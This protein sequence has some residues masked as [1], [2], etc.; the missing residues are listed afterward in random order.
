MTSTVQKLEDITN[1]VLE[2]LTGSCAE[3]GITSDIIGRPSFACYPESPTHV[4]YRA[5]LEGSS[6]TDSGSLISLIDDWVSG[7]ASIIVTGVLMAVDSECSVA[8]SSLSEGEC[9]VI[10]TP[11]TDPTT[12]STMTTMDPTTSSNMTTTDS[13]TNSGTAPSTDATASTSSSDNTAA[14]I[15]GVV[16]VILIISIAI[17]VIIIAIVAL[18]MKNRRGDLSIEKADK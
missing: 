13:T 3:C 16:A 7:G 2:E 1:A 4:T 8:I 10:Q 14:I 15:G 9:S 17:T 6:E 5:R 11:T 18:V 12:S